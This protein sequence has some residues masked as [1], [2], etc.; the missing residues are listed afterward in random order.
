MQFGSLS[1]VLPTNEQPSN[2]AVNVI[3]VSSMVKL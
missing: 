1:G 2:Y 3:A